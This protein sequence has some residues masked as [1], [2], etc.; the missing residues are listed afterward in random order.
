MITTSSAS[1]FG[2]AYSILID[3]TAQAFFGLGVAV[4]VFG[5]AIGAACAVYSLIRHRSAAVMYRQLH[6]SIGYSILLGLE[7]IVAGD[8]IH[9]I[10][11]SPTLEHV[12]VL[13]LI[14]VMRTIL[15]FALRTELEG[16]WPWQH[17]HRGCGCQSGSADAG[18]PTKKLITC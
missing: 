3:G 12:A 8:I 5:S 1:A 17:S 15:S 2:E 4:M 9:S 16:R 10:V 7:L 18:K 11:G 14:V 13:G 6:Q